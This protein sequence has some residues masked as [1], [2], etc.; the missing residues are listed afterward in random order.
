MVPDK[1]SLVEYLNY[2]ADPIN[3]YEMTVWSANLIVST[4]LRRFVAR[5]SGLRELD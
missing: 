4:S 5:S 2:I 3:H 1:A